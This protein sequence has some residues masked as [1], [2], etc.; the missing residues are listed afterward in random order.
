VIKQITR[1]DLQEVI[2]LTKSFWRE[3]VAES[4]FGEFDPL[5]FQGVLIRAFHANVL[6]GWAS[7]CKSKMTGVLLAAEDQ[8][9]WKKVLF[10]KEVMWYTLPEHRGSTSSIRLLKCLENFAKEKKYHSIMMGTISGTPNHDRMHKFYLKNK[11]QPMENSYI[12]TL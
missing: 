12:K 9:V 7:F 6:F 1:E 3:S 11:F 8:L 5:Y 4:L 2:R 10:L